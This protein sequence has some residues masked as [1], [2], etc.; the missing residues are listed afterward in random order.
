MLQT[1]HAARGPEFEPL[2][3][4]LATNPEGWGV[5]ITGLDLRLRGAFTAHTGCQR[6]PG[7]GDAPACDNG[8]NDD[9]DHDGHADGDCDSAG[10]EQVPSG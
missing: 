4:W 7:H 8:A 1:A 5:A 10:D 2:G 9:A 6:A 3:T